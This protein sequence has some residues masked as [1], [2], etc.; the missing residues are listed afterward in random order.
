MAVAYVAY[1]QLTAEK[2]TRVAALLKKNPYYKKQWKALIPTGTPADQRDLMLFMIAATWPDQIKEKGSVYQNDGDTP[3]TDGSAWTN[4]GYKDLKQHKYW[5]FI[6]TP[7]TQDNTAPLAAIPSPNAETQIAVFRQ[8]LTSGSKDKLKSYD[9]VWL[10][11]LVGD[12]HQ[13]LHS[14]TRIGAGEPGGDHGGNGVKVD[15]T[16]V[17]NTN[18]KLHLLWDS[19]P[20]DTTDSSAALTAAIAYGK[21]LAPAD[22]VL[23]KKMDAS[24]W[25]NESFAIAETSVYAAPIGTGDG[26]FTITPAY[27]D[28]AKKI[29]AE[30]VALAG[31][32][33]ANLINNELK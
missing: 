16:A 20:G 24:D 4:T 32:R 27:M 31:Q 23:A 17:G 9:L 19:L 11:H 25:I 12:V 33:M 15:A 10:L 2:K 13:P 18:K 8:T 22:P 21:S 26:P 7:F 5:H 14:T 28:N 29:A 1:Q 3:P 6:D 30:R